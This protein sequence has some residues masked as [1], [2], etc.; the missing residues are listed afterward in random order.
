MAPVRHGLDDLHCQQPTC[1]LLRRLHLNCIMPCKP[2]SHPTLSAEVELLEKIGAVSHITLRHW[3]GRFYERWQWRYGNQVPRREGAD[4]LAINFCE[5]TITHAGTQES[6]Y[7]N[8]FGTNHTLT[9]D[10]VKPSIQA[11]RARWKTETENHH[12][13]KKHG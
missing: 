13:L 3:N 2:D 7:R 9:A 12:T 4:A 5:V 8:G 1:A 11:G 6:L 10:T